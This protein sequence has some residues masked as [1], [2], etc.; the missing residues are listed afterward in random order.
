[1]S[2]FSR[3][4]K[5]LRA[6]FNLNVRKN[7][8]PVDGSFYE[9]YQKRK[10]SGQQSGR[11]AD[12]NFEEGVNT[13]GQDSELAQYYANLEVPYGSDLETVTRAWKAL[14]KKYHPD[15]HSTDPEKQAIANDL[16]Q[17]LN[18]AYKML[19]KHLSS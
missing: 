4:A 3:I 10:R 16:V 5:I 8:K 17:Q 1:M 12:F 2:V 6:N 18:H 19:E 11:R 14:L 13:S 9:E 15:M 7:D